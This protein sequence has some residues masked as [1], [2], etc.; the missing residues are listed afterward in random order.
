MQ[1]ISRLRT[2]A[3]LACSL[4]LMLAC[5]THIKQ[6]P[7]AAEIESVGMLANN[8]QQP[9]ALQTLTVWAQ[10]GNIIASRE[11]GN[12]LA[13]NTGRQIEA[14]HWLR[15]AAEGGD[16]AA[17]FSLAEVNY[18]GQL[19]SPQNYAQAWQWYWAASRQQHNKASLMLSRMCKYGEGVPLDINQSVQWLQTASDQGN[20]QAMFLLSN[21]Y[22][23]GEGVKTDPLL[24]RL[25][26]ERA[27]E[28]DFPVAIQALA[29]ELSGQ[30]EIKDQDPQRARHLLKEATDERKM[31][32]NQY[33]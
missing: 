19:G 14:L 26:L 1:T 4:L 33:Q 18:K 3:A 27:A 11:L 15:Q 31:R 9:E 2:A 8:T 25:W 32:W 6:N 21:A 24:A 5:T 13:G 17:Q 30:P 29:M 12:A 20:A 28:G 22:A 23:S 16:R 10:Q 7:S